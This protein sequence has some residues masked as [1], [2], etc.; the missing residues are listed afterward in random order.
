MTLRGAQ[1][2]ALLEGQFGSG[3][4]PRILQVSAGFSYLYAYDR[5]HERAVVSELHLNGRPIDLAKTYRV[6][7]PAFLAAGGDNFAILKIG[8]R[9]EEGPIDLDALVSYLGKVSSAAAPLDAPL[10][11]RI[12]GDACK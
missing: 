6:T 7:V 12:D 11:R 10:G 5:A 8:E 2:L 4:E 9:R 3:Q 1:I